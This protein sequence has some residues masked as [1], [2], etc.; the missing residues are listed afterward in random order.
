VDK[1]EQ[2]IKAGMASAIARQTPELKEDKARAIEMHQTGHDTGSISRALP[3]R[4]RTEIRRWLIAAG[5]Y[6][7]LGRGK[8]VK[9]RKRFNLD[10]IYVK[11]FERET[12]MAARFDENRHWRG[13]PA[14]TAVKQ[15]R[16]YYLNHATM[17]EKI[18]KRDLKRTPAQ[19]IRHR[20]ASRIRR[21]MKRYGRGT[22]KTMQT[23]KYI[24]CSIAEFR[25]HIAKQFTAG[26]SWNNYGKGGWHIDHRRPCALFDLSD[27]KQQLEC[28]HYSNLQ[29]LW[30]AENIR[31]SDNWSPNDSASLVKI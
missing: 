26:M 11:E 4:H 14:W 22:R 23:P 30:Q 29:P 27:P 9:G 3:G 2:A 25:E 13:H 31:K 19:T 5:V 24:G 20:L 21:A 10:K 17:L 8:A 12:K 28:F 18:R 16:R 1:T 15:L 7:T 6:H